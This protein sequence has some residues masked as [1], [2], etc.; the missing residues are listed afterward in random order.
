[1]SCVPSS[2]HGIRDCMSVASVNLTHAMLAC[3][4]LA[5]VHPYASHRVH[6]HDVDI[7]SPPGSLNTDGVDP[8]SC[9][10]V[11]IENMRYTGGDDAIAIKSGDQKHPCLLPA[12]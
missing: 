7:S 2:I 10:D 5:T 1:M 4:A 6:V 12:T 3:V 11:V 8:D 9:E